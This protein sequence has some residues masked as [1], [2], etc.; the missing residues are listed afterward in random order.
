[1][2]HVLAIPSL[3]ER[4]GQVFVGQRSLLAGKATAFREV[5]DVTDSE[6]F[7]RRTAEV[8]VTFWPIGRSLTTNEAVT[9]VVPAL[10]GMA[11]NFAAGLGRVEAVEVDVKPDGPK[12]HA[13]LRVTFLSQVP[14]S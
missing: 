6:G 8:E 9:R 14:A 13:S 7:R 2:G 10:E 4:A 11:D 5:K 3:I 1:M 12:L